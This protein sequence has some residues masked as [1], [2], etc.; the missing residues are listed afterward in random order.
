M[1]KSIIPHSRPTIGKEEIEAVSKVIATGQI[2]QGS[3]VEAFEAE[4]ASKIGVRYAAAVSS[5]TAALH[6]SLIALG[7][8]SGDEVIIPSYVCTALLN[9]VNYT[10]ATPVVADI[11]P[12]TLNIDP[13]DV[14]RRIS[15]STKAIIVPHM[16]GLMAD[17]ERLHKFG[18]PLIEDCAQAVGASNG[19]S[20]AGSIGEVGIYSFYAT[21]MMTCG[22]G[23]MVVSDS[24]DMIDRVRQG[25]EYDNRATYSVRFNY[26]MTDIQ[27]VMGRV[28]LE[29]LKNF[30][31]RRREIAGLYNQAFSDLALSRPRQAGG[32][33]F[34]RYNITVN[35]DITWWVGEMENAGI[36]CAKPVY[37]PSHHY[38]DSKACPHTDL[39][40]QK[41]LSIPIYPTLSDSDIERVVAAVSK[42]FKK[43]VLKN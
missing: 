14:A 19:N 8:S 1:K 32:H 26:K 16:F 35:Q 34:Y 15:P 42:T 24:R 37:R 38:I 3:Q 11:D 36:A 23:G 30:V 43:Y 9:A 33:I 18:I 17:M 29:K 7:V 40:F 5:G 4:F 27:A 10:G 13:Q 21:K 28:Q 22:E 41:T 2:A 25:R 12:G 39:A 20:M 31:D 6:L